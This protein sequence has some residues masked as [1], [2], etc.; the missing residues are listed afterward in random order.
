MENWDTFSPAKRIAL[1]RKLHEDMVLF[2]LLQ[3]THPALAECAFLKI[4]GYHHVGLA[5]DTHGGGLSIAVRDG[6]GVEVGV[7]EKEVPERATVALWLSAHVNQMITSASFPRK[8]GVSSTSLKQS[9]VA[10]GPPVMGADVNSHHTLWD[11][12]RPS[13]AKGEYMVE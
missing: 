13:D 5:I 11:P 2:C 4:S 10:S 3:E 12:L 1:D 9:A 7:L 8:A 6:V